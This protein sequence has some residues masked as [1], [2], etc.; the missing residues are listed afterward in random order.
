M[1]VSI[2]IGIQKRIRR[3]AGKF[4]KQKNVIRL[5]TQ[6]SV[7]LLRINGSTVIRFINKK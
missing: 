3:F 4:A 2:F 5:T 7:R 6:D 1:I